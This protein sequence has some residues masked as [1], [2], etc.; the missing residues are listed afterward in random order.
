MTAGITHN[1]LILEYDGTNYSGSQLQA[2]EPTIQSEIE[3]ALLSEAIKL[4]H[5]TKAK[6]IEL[7]HIYPIKFFEKD[8]EADL[9]RAK[10]SSQSGSSCLKIHTTT[11]SHKV[12]MLLELPE[13][14]EL[15]MNAFKSKLRSQIKKPLK[16]GLKAKIGGLELFHDFYKVFSVNMRDLGS[17]LHSKRL[18]H[19]VLEEFP[20]KARIVLIHKDNKPVACSVIVGFRDT[21]ENP[22]ASSLNNYS[23]MAPNMLLYW[24]MLEYACD[25]GYNKFDF[26]RSTPDEGTYKFKEQWGAKPTP[27]HWHYLSLNG[28]T[29][30]QE[31][32]EK[33]KISRPRPRA[34]RLIKSPPFCLGHIS[35]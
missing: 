34:S 6:T 10:E 7:R 11:K 26:G 30:D 8:S 32:S 4:G 12:R 25:N 16:E 21:L 28:T 23:R 22:W 15:L 17:P 24:T 20:E 31:T 9:I 27:L 35:C 19:H 5:E 1:A 33:S 29:I 18:I 2:K 13:S 14:S 3:K